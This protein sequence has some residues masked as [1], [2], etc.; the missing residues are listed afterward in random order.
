MNTGPA[1]G[2]DPIEDDARL[3]RVVDVF[4]F[5]ALGYAVALHATAQDDY[6]HP[7]WAWGVLG[8]LAAWTV[9]LAVRPG[10]ETAVMVI[11]LALAGSSVLATRAL[12]A[13]ERIQAGAQTLPSIWPAAA[14]LAWAIWR[15]W[16]GGLVAALV[17]AV[18]DVAEIG[19]FS[20]MSANGTVNNI[21]LL[22]LS[23]LIVGY[24]VEVLRAG[25]TQLTAA[26]AQQAAT[27]E[28]ERLA[29][30]IHDSVLQ[31]LG[32][33]HRDGTERGGAAG[34]LARLAGE[35][36]ARLRALISNGSPAPTL[37]G[38]ADLRAALSRHAGVRVSIS[39]PALPVLLP[40]GQ[41]AALTAATA[42]AL[43]NVRQHAGE[44]ARAWVL[45]EDEPEQVTVTVR[46]DG[47]GIE[48]D[49]LEAARLAGRLGVSASICGRIKEIG[50][51]VEFVCM[52]GEGTEV[53]LRVPR[54]G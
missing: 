6:L 28:R 47:P 19:G 27:A 36:E 24:A 43:D 1:P 21:V 52:P 12:D 22:I 50:G 14:V 4:R 17:I 2:S 11:D 3:W 40:A 16:R 41:V 23:G 15:G 10:R 8:V 13:P 53:E 51:T 44:Q 49:R 39:C 5:A 18:T 9:F 7:W 29:R 34:D 46:D 20:Q 30:D 33:V 32:F 45:L 25:Q 42:A 37:V 48:P 38:E 35:Q 26:A 54:A 31:V